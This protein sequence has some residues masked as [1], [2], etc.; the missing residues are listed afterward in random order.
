M[1]EQSGVFYPLTERVTNWAHHEP[2]T[3]LHRVVTDLQEYI[4]G[5]L[6]DDMAIVVARRDG[7]AA[8]A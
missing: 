8:A 4:N 3:L 7:K 6:D 2:E 1:G 5:H